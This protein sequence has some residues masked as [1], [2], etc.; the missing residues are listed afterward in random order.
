MDQP[1][2][3]AQ[4]IQQS[5]TPP[6]SLTHKQSLLQPHSHRVPTTSSGEERSRETE[7][8][9]PKGAGERPARLPG[10]CPSCRG[11]EVAG[12]EA[13]APRSPCAGIPLTGR[14]SR[15][16]CSRTPSP[17]HS[18][19]RPDTS[20]CFNHICKHQVWGGG[21]LVGCFGFFS[22]FPSKQPFIQASGAPQESSRTAE[23]CRAGG[24]PSTARRFVLPNRP[25]ARRGRAFVC[26][27]K[28]TERPGAAATSQR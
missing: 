4:G 2:R 8:S 22:D 25:P 14:A 15:P 5:P 10:R 19:R 24:V 28:G 12:G 21:E 11:T 9:L 23:E 3:A 6:A 17:R 1:W 27:S 18:Q 7:L 13:G 20:P 16:L 26:G